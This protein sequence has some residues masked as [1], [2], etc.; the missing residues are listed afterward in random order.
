MTHLP[1]CAKP[2]QVGATVPRSEKYIRRSGS[3]ESKSPYLRAVGFCIT[4][5]ARV[6][7]P[8]SYSRNINMGSCLTSTRSPFFSASIANLFFSLAYNALESIKLQHNLCNTYRTREPTQ[9]GPPFPQGKLPQVDP[10]IVFVFPFGSRVLRWRRC[11]CRVQL[12]DENVV[13]LRG[14]NGFTA[15]QV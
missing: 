1:T 12:V 8:P 3:G 15:F 2:N 5:T 6:Y 9:T 13:L 4:P 14:R 7:Y 10:W 11:L